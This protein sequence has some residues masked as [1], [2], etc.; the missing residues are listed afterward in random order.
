M[1]AISIQQTKRKNNDDFAAATITTTTTKDIEEIK[2]KNVK[3]SKSGRTN[4]EL[5]R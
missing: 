3:C 5:I 4:E 2:V 1:P